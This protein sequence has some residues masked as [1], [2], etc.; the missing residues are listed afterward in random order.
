MDQ[1]FHVVGRV[2]V[3][4][5]QC[6]KRR[7][8]PVGF[9]KERAHGR[10]VAV[11]GRQEID[12]TTH[13]SQCFDVIFKRA[14]RDGGFARVRRRAAQF[15]CGDLF[16]GHG[17]HHVRACHE[18]IGRVFNHE[19]KVSHRRGIDRTA[20]TWPH[21]HADLRDHTGGFDIALEHLGITCEA[22]DAFL[23]TRTAGIVDPDDR[24]TVLDRHILNL[25]D[26]LR[27]GL[28]QRSAKD[29]EILTEDIDQTAV[30]RAPTGDNAVT[31]GFLLLHPEVGAA[32][33]D[34]HVEFFKRPII[35]QQ[36]D[37]LAGGQLATGVLR[38]NAL[39][40]SAQS[41]VV[42]AGFKL[43]QNIFHHAPL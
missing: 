39:L 43:F 31:C 22:V 8:D 11:V 9:V 28:G 42:A 37:P 4:G 5:H 6:I 24:R 38:I 27:V 10:Q 34:E 40:P 17:F 33:G 21:D 18:H 30:D 25:A 15:L 19:D 13:L 2:G 1:L 41:G 3:A 35:K 12:Q 32:V 29:R 23:N 20:R 14:I 26:L 16:V 7:L 36:V